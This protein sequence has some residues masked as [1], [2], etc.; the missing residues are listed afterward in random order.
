MIIRIALRILPGLLALF[1]SAAQAELFVIVNKNNSVANLNKVDI[2]RIFLRKTKRFE[3]EMPADPVSQDEDSKVRQA[4]NVKILGR[5]QGKLKYYWSRKMFAG[6]DKPPP[7]VWDNS[8]VIEYVGTN[9][10]GIGYV[11]IKPKD[12]RVKVVYHVKD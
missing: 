12:D 8:E 1:V 2:E 6:G 5:D 9:E 10:G 4:F 11:D 3:N 7:T